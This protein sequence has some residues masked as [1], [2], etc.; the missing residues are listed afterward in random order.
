MNQNLLNIMVWL[1]FLGGLV[2]FV[3]A[4]VKLFGGGT[5]VEYGVLGIG[6]GLWFMFSAITILISQK[7]K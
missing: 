1:L 4:L 5:P 7:T 2:G 3:M 6:G